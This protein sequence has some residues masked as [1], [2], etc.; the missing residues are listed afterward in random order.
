MFDDLQEITADFCEYLPQLRILDLRDNKIE[1]LPDEVSQLHNLTRLDLSNNSILS[2]P[3]SLSTLSHLVS[4]QV[5]GNPIRSIRRDII[6]CG[7]T[8]VMKILK[9][10]AGNKEKIERTNVRTPGDDNGFPDRFQM[11]KNHTMNVSARNLT[12]IPENVFIEASEA[13]VTNVNL[14]KNRLTAIPDG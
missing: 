9:D 8:R 7:T 2:L 1:K 10:R 6:Q 4:L 3:C 12:E 14:S 13:S 11:K 5:E